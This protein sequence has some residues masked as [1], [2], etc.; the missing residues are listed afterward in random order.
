MKSVFICY[1]YDVEGHDTDTDKQLVKEMGAVSGGTGGW[2]PHK[3]QPI[4]TF[5]AGLILLQLSHEQKNGTERL[6]EKVLQVSMYK[7]IFTC[8]H[9]YIHI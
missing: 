5:G 8:I 9:I 4:S 6:H 7:C 1:Y 3:S 2:C